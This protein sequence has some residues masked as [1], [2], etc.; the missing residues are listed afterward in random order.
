MEV[1]GE[2]GIANNRV[3][4]DELFVIQVN[5]RAPIVPRQFVTIVLKPPSGT[6]LSLI[7]VSTP[8]NPS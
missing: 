7:R 4:F 1:I 5:P 3:E 2:E 6:P 8:L